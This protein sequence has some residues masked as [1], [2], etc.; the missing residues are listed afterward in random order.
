MLPFNIHTCISKN[1]RNT[2]ISVSFE[3]CC[4]LRRLTSNCIE[5]DGRHGLKYLIYHLMLNI[6]LFTYFAFFLNKNILLIL[7]EVPFLFIKEIR[8]GRC[9]LIMI[10]S[11]SR[12]H[13]FILS[14][15][16]ILMNKLILEHIHL[17]LFFI[18]IFEIIM[19]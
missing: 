9:W 19:L 16:F 8:Q 2:G 13:L 12:K 15:L 7:N 5:K 11:F 1:I 6:L 10:C 14:S 18:T 3:C 17:W 4:Y